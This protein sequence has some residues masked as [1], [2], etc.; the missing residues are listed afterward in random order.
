MRAWVSEAKIW[1]DSCLL[2]EFQRGTGALAAGAAVLGSEG[3]V[4]CVHLLTI[5]VDDRE[6]GRGGPR[7]RHFDA[8]RERAARLVPV[9]KPRIESVVA[10]RLLH[11]ARFSF[12]QELLTRIIAPSSHAPVLCTTPNVR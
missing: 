8:G 3:S 10:G 12:L 6:L 5:I 1:T 4:T 7:A 2:T 11:S 9:R